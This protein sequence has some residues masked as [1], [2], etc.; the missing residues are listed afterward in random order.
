VPQGPSPLHQKRQVWPFAFYQCEWVHAWRSHGACSAAWTHF[1]AP[2]RSAVRHR[3]GFWP[4]ASTE[5][6]ALV[7]ILHSGAALWHAFFRILQLIQD[8]RLPAW[9]TGTQY[10][11]SLISSFRAASAWWLGLNRCLGSGDLSWLKTGSQLGVSLRFAPPRTTPL[12]LAIEGVSLGG[13]RLALGSLHRRRHCQATSAR[14]YV[15][16]AQG[17]S[18]AGWHNGGYGFRWIIRMHD[19]SKLSTG[20]NRPRVTVKVGPDGCSGHQDR[21]AMRQTGRSTAPPP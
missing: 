9:Y 14:R 3:F 18:Y 20:H 1:G 16:A 17:A 5:W 10:F 4:V 19:G 13:I 15:A 6:F 7:M 8:S 21:A 2:D 11:V 12:D